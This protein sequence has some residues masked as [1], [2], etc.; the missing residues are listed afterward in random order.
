VKN[1]FTVLITSPRRERYREYYKLVDCHM[2]NF[3]VFYRHEVKD[4]LHT[5][6]PHLVPHEKQVW[7][8][9]EKWG[10]I[11]RYVLSKI[12]KESQYLLE[13][14]LT[15]I[16]LDELIF[17]LG[18][19]AIE[20]DDKASHRLLHLK[21]EGGGE[22]EFSGPTFELASYVLAYTELATPFIRTLVQKAM[23]EHHYTRLNQL[24][25][26]PLVSASFSRFYGDQYQ[27]GAIE[28]LLKGGESFQAFDCSTGKE[29]A[30]GIKVPAST[31]CAFTDAGHLQRLVASNAGQPPCLY[32]PTSTTYTAVDA[33]LPNC[34]LVN[35]TINV[36]HTAK[37]Y[38]KGPK[39]GEGIAPVADALGIKGDI[40][41]YWVLPRARYVEACRA[42]DPFEVTDQRPDD[43]RTLKQYFVCVPFDFYA[44]DPVGNQ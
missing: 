44:A 8:R 34:V 16:N 42:K 31:R 9:F 22:D 35:C 37:M 43:T 32:E 33:V 27:R 3:P 2:V 17:D 28:Q 11:V 13:D 14:A 41:F 4:M 19:R 25:A 1:A 38:G 40:V 36:K 7:E 15:A 21:P 39:S 30:G 20:S 26:Q 5:C 29:V 6:F 10:G 12:D 23:K 24:L 18:A